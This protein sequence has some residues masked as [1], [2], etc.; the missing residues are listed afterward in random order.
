MTENKAKAALPRW[1]IRIHD[2]PPNGRHVRRDRLEPAEAA[3]FAAA[4]GV[5]AVES[6]LLDVEIKPYHGDGLAVSGTVEAGVVQTC[7]VTLEPVQ[8]RIA[9]EVDA[10][11][12]P[13][14]KLKAHLV[15]DE[16]DGL[17]IDASV[18]ADDPLIGG[19][20]DLAAIAA[21]FLALA[22]DPYPRRSDAVFE[23][24]E[25]GAE[26]SPF[27]TLAKLRRDS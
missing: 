1:S 22:V 4:I 17:A 18:A 5:D 16:E 23:T 13:T 6:L 12:R 24:P 27:A 10:T 20:I 11:F 9:E 25:G 14:D 19:E 21:E 3:A 2:V 7:V 8:N 26:V 15:H